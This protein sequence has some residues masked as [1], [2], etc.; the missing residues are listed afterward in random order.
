MPLYSEPYMCLATLHLFS[1]GI[2][3]EPHDIPLIACVDQDGS[4]LG[5][6]PLLIIHQVPLLEGPQVLPIR[7]VQCLSMI[8][9]CVL[10]AAGRGGCRG[11]SWSTEQEPACPPRRHC[12]QPSLPQGQDNSK[13][14]K[15]LTTLQGHFTFNFDF[16]HTNVLR[17]CLALTG[18]LQLVHHYTL[19][20]LL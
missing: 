6:Q 14:T 11:Q 16:N 7:V 10:A 8:L 12:P 3:A 1:Y 2:L 17:I 19:S 4:L 20:V 15:H 5:G 9:R 13:H 18:R